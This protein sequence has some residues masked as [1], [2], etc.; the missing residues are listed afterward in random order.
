MN[1]P[2]V[3]IEGRYCGPPV[4]GNGGWTAGAVAALLDGQAEVTLRRPPP[5]DRP[6]A[7]TRP[8]HDTVVVADADGV[9]AEAR[10]IDPLNIAH[11]PTVTPD[12]ALRASAAYLDAVGV[13]AFPT[14]FVCGPD[15]AEGDG[16]RLFSGPVPGREGLV[17]APWTPHESIAT[18]EGLVDRRAVWAALDC[19]GGLSHILSGRPSV[20][21][22]MAAKIHEQPRVGSSYT[23]IGWSSP[24]DGRKLPAHSAIVDAETD[25]II[26]FARST[27][28]EVDPSHFI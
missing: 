17:A 13:H 28:I 14:C 26:A 15:R 16:L 2:T 21:G 1:A 24:A 9:V 11:V 25:A 4:S 10:R 3:T 12:D 7:V 19:P 27:W 23:V 22:R 5:L 18:E 20:L 6:L 8:D